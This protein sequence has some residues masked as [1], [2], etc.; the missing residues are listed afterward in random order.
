[1]ATVWYD[2]ATV[3]VTVVVVVAGSRVLTDLV[4][5]GLDAR[6]Q[7][8]YPQDLAK[9]HSGGRRTKGMRNN[10][11][12]GRTHCVAPPGKPSL[13]CLQSLPAAVSVCSL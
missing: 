11:A 9:S 8:K 12:A 1:M 5:A 2:D 3:V 4:Q 6:F 7:V 13:R 10:P